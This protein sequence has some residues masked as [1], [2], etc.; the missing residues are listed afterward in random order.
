MGFVTSRQVGKTTF[1][2]ML[3]VCCKLMAFGLDWSLWETYKMYYAYCIHSKWNQCCTNWQISLMLALNIHHLHLYVSH[4]FCTY[5]QCVHSESW[6]KLFVYYMKTRIRQK[7]LRQWFWI[8]LINIASAC[9]KCL[10]PSHINIFLYS[11]S[12]E[13]KLVMELRFF[14]VNNMKTHQDTQNT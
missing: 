11:K 5:T 13:K 12:V 8:V 4:R 7:Q 6:E 2:M 9:N 1:N 3:N 14:L 10:K